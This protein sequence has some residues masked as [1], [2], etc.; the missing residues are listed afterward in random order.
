MCDSFGF[1]AGTYY[2]ALVTN[3][4]QSLVGCAGG[5]GESCNA[6]NMTSWLAS[7]AEVVGEYG[8]TCQVD[9]SNSTE[10]MST[11]WYNRSSNLPPETQVCHK[12]CFADFSSRCKFLFKREGASCRRNPPDT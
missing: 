5:P 4:P 6:A 10:F 3:S 12:T 9:Y 2:R 11:S 7:R 1:D 8:T